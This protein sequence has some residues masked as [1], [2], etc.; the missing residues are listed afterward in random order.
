MSGYKTKGRLFFKAFMD[1]YLAYLNPNAIEEVVQKVETMPKLAA[2]K[3]VT[4]PVEK[5]QPAKPKQPK[6]KEPKAKPA[7]VTLP[8]YHKVEMGESLYKIAKKYKISIKKLIY[9]NDLETVKIKPGK[10]LRIR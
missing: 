9:L 8:V 1:A 6:A 2:E 10:K 4:L 3:Q 7:K 5:P